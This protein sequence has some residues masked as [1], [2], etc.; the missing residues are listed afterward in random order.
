MKV[1][2]AQEPE[3]VVYLGLQPQNGIH[4]ALEMIVKVFR[5]TSARPLRPLDRARVCSASSAADLR[6]CR[7]R[8]APWTRDAADG[9][10]LLSPDLR[11]GTAKY[12]NQ[13][14]VKTEYIPLQ[15]AGIHGNGHM[16]MIEKNNLAIAK[17]ID[18]W[19]VKNVK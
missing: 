2:A 4:H 19:V 18:D 12:L 17:V 13:A 15:N 3:L 1:C 8:R 5:R 9:G 14:G 16:V 6:A 7:G 10:S 11:H